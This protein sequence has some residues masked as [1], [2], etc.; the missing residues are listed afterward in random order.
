MEYEYEKITLID[1]CLVEGSVYFDNSEAN[2][3]LI[4][5]TASSIYP[6]VKFEE[7]I[8]EINDYCCFVQ[9]NLHEKVRSIMDGKADR[10]S[11]LTDRKRLANIEKDF[12][13]FVFFIGEAEIELGYANELLTWE[14]LANDISRCS[15]L[16]LW[17]AYLETT[18]DEIGHW[19]CEE[20]KIPFGR[21]SRSSTSVEHALQ[22][23]GECCQCDM[24]AIL[25]KELIFY[26]EVQ[27]IRNQ[28][29]HRE[30]EQVSDRFER[31]RLNEVINL[32]ST[33]IASIEHEALCACIISS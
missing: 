12:P 33:I 11:I 15:M 30:W 32:V 2:S 18:L 9:N 31:F 7:E 23:I 10:F 17:L 22:K 16:A 6:F 5:C 20:K 3:Y 27:K 21:K 14:R 1:D 19:F 24:P 26:Q 4:Y 28:F 29:M 25:S 8:S 13:D